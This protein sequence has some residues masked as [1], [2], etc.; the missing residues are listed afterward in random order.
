MQQNLAMFSFSID[1]QNT[2]FVQEFCSA[3]RLSAFLDVQYIVPIESD[4]ENTLTTLLLRLKNLLCPIRNF[5]DLRMSLF[6][7]IFHTLS[8]LLQIIR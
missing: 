5:L 6:N 4:T 1:T 2:M 7:H 8:C 3:L